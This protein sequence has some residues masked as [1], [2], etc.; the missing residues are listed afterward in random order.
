MF[1]TVNA[2]AGWS[3]V[4]A[5]LTDPRV[6]VLAVDPLS[7]STVYAGTAG[8]VFKT[9]NGGGT[10]A[11]VNTGLMNLT[12]QA[13][14]V[15]PAQ[16]GTVYAGTAFGLFKTADGGAN[17]SFINS[18]FSSASVSALLLDPRSPATVY[19]GTGTTVFKSLDNGASWNAADSGLTAAGITAL[20]IDPGN[21]ATL[22]AGTLSGGVFRTINGGSSWTQENAGLTDLRIATLAVDPVSPATVYAGTRGSGAFK[23]VGGANCS[24]G[25]E[26]LCLN[27]GR[28]R[29]QVAWRAVNIGTSGA[30][31]AIV[32]TSDTGAFWFFSANNLELIVK[33]VDGR[34]FN[35]YFWVF[36]GALSDVEYTITVTDTQTGAVKTYFNPQG[37]L[38][39]VADTAAFPGG[40]VVVNSSI[41]DSGL[42]TSD[43]GLPAAQA[44]CVAS[45]TTLCVNGSRFQVTVNWRAANIGASG[46]GQAVPLTSD[47]GAFWFFSSGNLELVL[48][49][50][51]G[52]AFNGKFWV[53]FGALSNV[54]YTITV[55]DTQ[56]GAVKT[57]FNPQGRLASVADT[58]AF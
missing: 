7:A 55:T 15:H 25:P 46:A 51:D 30:G 26:A 56:T 33:V 37:R 48:K 24:A 32:L 36:A 43:F 21:P 6:S 12:V 58:A 4:N 5:G 34:A 20:A 54:E 31:Q 11:A 22:Y 47:T 19:A 52:R 2:G 29:V 57:Y 18:G 28:F 27:N 35:N 9:V 53:F 13:L 44:T 50:V 42:R 1:K 38:A 23:N 10:W 17:W 16:P 41:P 3:A 45:A 40:G 49:V 14:A 39:S 8:G